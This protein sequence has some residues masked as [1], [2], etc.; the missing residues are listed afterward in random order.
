M[1]Q[2][3]GSGGH[4][5]RQANNK[6]PSFQFQ[7]QSKAGV[8]QQY[9]GGANAASNTMA[10][11]SIERGGSNLMMQSIERSQSPRE[12]RQY[13]QSSKQELQDRMWN[14]SDLKI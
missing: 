13:L 7:R 5:N 10:S 4:F 3:Q 1:L 11:S 8:A 6:S 14:R 9:G 12:I 2:Y